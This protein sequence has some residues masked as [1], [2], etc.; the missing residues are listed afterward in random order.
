MQPVSGSHSSAP[1][2]I[3]QAVT[4]F[5]ASHLGSFIR[6]QL[7]EK[8]CCINGVFFFFEVNMPFI[9]IKGPKPQQAA[10]GL[11]KLGLHATPPA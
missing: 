7:W 5:I 4:T 3:Q 9:K 1:V 10:D 8:V 6:Y 11:H 2:V